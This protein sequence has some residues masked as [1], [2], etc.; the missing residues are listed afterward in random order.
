M[1]TMTRIYTYQVERPDDPLVMAV[2]MR[3]AAE[4]IHKHNKYVEK[5]EIAHP[6]DGS[7]IIRL[8]M[9]S[10]DQ[11]LIKKRVIYP[12]ANLLVKAGLTLKDARLLA[13]DKPQHHKQAWSE[14][15]HNAQPIEV[16]PA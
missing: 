15:Y 7:L 10:K 1:S 8:T 12:L 3:E 14:A 4:H 13:V 2:A 16:D 9:I 11:W 6:E 5:V